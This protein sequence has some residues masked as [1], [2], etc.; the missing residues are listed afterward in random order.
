MIESRGRLLGG[1]TGVPDAKWSL[2]GLKRK[3]HP[4][5]IVATLFAAA[6]LI[7]IAQKIASMEF[8]WIV[9]TLLKGYQNFITLIFEALVDWWFP[10]LLRKIAALI[11]WKIELFPQWRDVVALLG[12]Y[13]SSHIKQALAENVPHPAFAIVM[14]SLAGVIGLVLAVAGA[15][16]VDGNGFSQIVSIFAACLIGIATYRLGFAA[17]F[18]FDLKK[19]GFRSHFFDKASGVMTIV[20]GGLIILFSGLLAMRIS[21]PKVAPSVQVLFL[22]LLVFFL[23]VYHVWLAVHSEGRKSKRLDVETLEHAS[24]TGN[25]KIGMRI[26]SAWA[27]AG[28]AILTAGVI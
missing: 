20:L 5:S 11:G 2:S 25:F 7:S 13:L 19:D 24:V 1:E 3:F 10:A 8:V 4:F 16:V 14:R 17:Q 18:A 26:L 12:L 6:A 23:G 28:T 15:S 9:K 21:S 22:F 27:G